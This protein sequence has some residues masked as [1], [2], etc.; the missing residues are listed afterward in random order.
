LT[1]YG[2]YG[3]VCELGSFNACADV[4]FPGAT[5]TGN[6]IWGAPMNAANQF[7]PGNV[8]AG[9]EPKFADPATGDYALP[10]DSPYKGLATDG[11][12]SGVDVEAFAR[13]AACRS[14]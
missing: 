11:T 13:A 3:V 6:V 14:P 10:A 9:S 2:A 5:F 4:T 1:G 7:P 8:F 12:D